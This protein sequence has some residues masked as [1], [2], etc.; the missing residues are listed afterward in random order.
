MLDASSIPNHC[1]EA[2]EG[3]S[4]ELS[5]FFTS[6]DE[7]KSKILANDINLS[8]EIPESG[9]GDQRSTGGYYTLFQEL[10]EQETL[11]SQW[12][13]S[14]SPRTR[15]LTGHDQEMAFL[16]GFRELVMLLKNAQAA[17]LVYRIQSFVKRAEQWNL[18]QMLRARTMRDRPGGRIQSFI[19]KLVEQIKHSRK[20]MKLLHGDGVDGEV[21]KFLHIRDESGEGLLHEVLEAFLMEKLYTK[22]LTP[23][24]EVASKDEVLHDRINLLGFVTFK[25]LDLPVPKTEEQEQ[26]W[27]TMLL[28]AQ[29]GGKFPSADEFLP[30][31]I[32]VLLR[33]NPKELKRNVAF[34]LEYRNP[35]KLVSEP[36]YFFTHLVSSVAF[37]EE[38]NGSLLTISAEEFDEGLRRSKE[39]LKLRGV[40]SEM[41]HEVVSN[42]S[43]NGVN[44]EVPNGTAKV[45]Q[46]ERH[47][48]TLPHPSSSITTEEADEPLRLPNVLEV[49]A[50]R[51]AQ[52]AASV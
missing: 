20:L 47:K 13:R 4:T 31:L 36:G 24:S 44:E 22:M 14:H 5:R 32:F 10:R 33:A 37:L 35:A 51:L 48:L 2:L 30:A 21:Q 15:R 49:R 8:E 41:D 6:L 16:V 3:I 7:L 38:V 29:N 26:T 42:A 11:L 34:I 40:N 52:F 9:S 1:R 23:S 45:L 19:T 46:N 27:L 50:K 18:P 17:E 39:S 25:H 28:K 43:S 12:Q